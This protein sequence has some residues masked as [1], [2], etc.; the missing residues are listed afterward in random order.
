MKKSRP[1]PKVWKPES[2]FGIAKPVRGVRHNARLGC[3]TAGGGRFAWSSKAWSVSCFPACGAG[4]AQAAGNASRITL[5]CLAAQAFREP[6]IAGQ[7][8]GLP[9]VRHVDVPHELPGTG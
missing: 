9:G 4:T 8:P 5:V 2:R 3:T 7:D 6:G 1:T